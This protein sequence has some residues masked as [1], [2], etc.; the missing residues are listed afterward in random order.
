MVV[1]DG[2]LVM[3][4]EVKG[5]LMSEREARGHGDLMLHF[6]RLVRLIELRDALKVGVRVVWGFDDGWG[7][8][9]SL[10]PMRVETAPPVNPPPRRDGRAETCDAEMVVMVPWSMLR[11]V[12]VPDL[13]EGRAV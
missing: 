6:A 1:S 4:V 13:V 9:W 5:R 2:V 11:K 3:G 7:G 12:P 8:L 10:D